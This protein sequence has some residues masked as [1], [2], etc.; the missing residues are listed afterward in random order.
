MSLSD[1][2]ILVTG[3]AGQVAL[4]VAASLVVDN[5]VWGIARFGDAD[6][7]RRVED[8][9]VQT[10]VVDLADPDWSA[11]PDRFDHVLH[12]AADITGEDYDRALRINAEGTGL[13]MTRFAH[14]RS[15]LVVSSSAVYDLHPDPGHEFTETDPLGDSKPLFGRTYPVSKIAQEA[16]ARATCR[17]VGLPTTVARLNLSYG[18][19]GGLPTYQLDWILNGDPV[20]VAD[21]ETFC[22]PLHQDDIVATVPRLLDV[23]SIPATVT[24]W[25]GADIVSMREYVAYLGELTGCEVELAPT[26]GF[27]RSRAVAVTRQEEL[28][29]RCSVGWRDGFRRLV[30]DRLDRP[31]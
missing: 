5:E 27:I 24:N 8:L 12:F 11:L 17:T 10:A 13:L 3:P 2:R 7:R 19:N 16:V 20:P 14:A 26:A 18:P 29:G 4:P 28:I 22:N 6:S 15:C 31:S 9:G 25:A 21:E 30:E 23:A 1:R